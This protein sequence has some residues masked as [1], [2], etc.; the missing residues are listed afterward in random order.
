MRKSKNRTIAY[1]DEQLARQRAQREASV[2]AGPAAQKPV[3]PY[4]ITFAPAEQC[5]DAAQ[6]LDAA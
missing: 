5:D 4:E 2:R 1:L 6:A 3:D